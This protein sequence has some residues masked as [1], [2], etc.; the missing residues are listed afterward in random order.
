MQ[1]HSILDKLLQARDLQQIQAKI[2]A[3]LPMNPN[4]TTKIYFRILKEKNDCFVFG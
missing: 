1:I 3:K 2:S 4:W